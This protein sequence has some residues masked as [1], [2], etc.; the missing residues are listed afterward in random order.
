M[1]YKVIDEALKVYSCGFDDLTEEHL[2]QFKRQY[3]NEEEFKHITVFYDKGNSAIVINAEHEYFDL[4]KKF[5]I[6]YLSADKAT[7]EEIKIERQRRNTKYSQGIIKVLDVALLDMS[8]EQEVTRLMQQPIGKMSD[9]TWGVLTAIQNKTMGC[10]AIYSLQ[11]AYNYGIMQGKRA[12][13]AR[14]R[15]GA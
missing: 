3:G 6:A 7:R 12:E 4:C 8:K 11:L 10:G 1:N 5:V 2:E 9:V 14:R 13:R 15:K